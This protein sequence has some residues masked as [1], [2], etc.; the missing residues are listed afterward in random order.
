MSLVPYK[1]TYDE[2]VKACAAIQI[3]FEVSED[4]RI[5]SAVKETEYLDKL[6]DLLI[7]SNPDFWIVRPKARHWYDIKINEI[8]INLKLTTGGT[9]NAFNKKAIAYSMSGDD[10]VP[11]N[12]NFDKWFA[13]LKAMPKKEV[14]D[15]ASEY[16]YLVLNK[17]T[18]QLL[19]KSI[20][21]IHSYKSNPCNDM[22][23]SWAQEF[24]NADYKVVSN[25]DYKAKVREL[26]KTVQ[27]SVKQ[28][29]ASMNDFASADIDALF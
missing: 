7:A 2:I 1:K 8:P 9:D 21:D 13:H 3:G 27:R 14:R 6:N 24:L 17:N 4:G 12:T 18:G 28:L 23:I 11:S 26:L 22:Q 29:I 25:E 16:H 15:R 19:F 20:F 10:D 5:E